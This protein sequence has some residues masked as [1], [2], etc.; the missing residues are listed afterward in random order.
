MSIRIKELAF[1]FYPVTD[2]PRA[3]EFYE[4]LLGLKPANQLEFAP[5]QWWIEYDIAGQALAISNA[6]PGNK[7]DNLVLEVVSLDETLQ[8]LREAKIPLIGEIT[9]FAPCRMCRIADPFGNEIGFHQ[10]KAPPA[11]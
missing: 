8:V 3:R 1:V 5:G 9:E 7:A 11:S 4:G 2:I 6:V 10:L